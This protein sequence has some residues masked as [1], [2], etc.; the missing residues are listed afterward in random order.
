M[1]LYI[2]RMRKR[3]R[4]RET[5]RDREREI[6]REGKKDKMNICRDLDASSVLRRRS[7]AACVYV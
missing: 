2:Y 1:C 3:K 5:E 4:Q 6:E 7:R